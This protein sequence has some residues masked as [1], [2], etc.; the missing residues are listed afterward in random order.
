MTAPAHRRQKENPM[1]QRKLIEA[2]AG[3]TVEMLEQRQLLSGGTGALVTQHN[4]TSDGFVTAANTDLKLKNP[5]GIAAAPGGP[6]WVSDNNSGFVTLYNGTGAAQPLVVTIPGGGGGTANPTGQVFNADGGFNVSKN[7]GTP[8]S[9]KFIFVGED[10][11]I[12]GWSP[13]VDPTNAILAVDNSASGAVYKGA[14]LVEAR[15]KTELLVTNFNSGAVEIYD[16]T[17]SRVQMPRAFQDRSIP[18]GFAPFNI[19]SVGGLIYVTY[20]K[21]NAAKH[22]D[23]GGPGAGFVDVYNVVGRLR[24]RLQ[25]GSFMNSPWGIA[26]V[27][28]SWGRLAGDIL[29]GQFKSGNINIFNPHS[30]N[31]VG[32]LRDSTNAPVAIDGLWAITPGSGSAT[33][34]NQSIFFT[35]GVNGEQDGLF[36]SL[37]F[38]RTSN[39][40]DTG[41]MY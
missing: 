12:S 34:S 13:S 33:S 6:L 22:D 25:H 1:R 15:G 20:A 24:E 2:A 30:G 21:Q 26:V 14:T 41:G 3:S 10:G 29:V 16:D 27:P 40:P 37:T 7:G 9:S 17:F 35:A 19:Q 36:G 32:T 23:V 38:N 5:W 11:G 4:L 18:K 31:F 28:S 39:Q 8:G